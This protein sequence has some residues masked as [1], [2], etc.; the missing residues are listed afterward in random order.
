MN[1]TSDCIMEFKTNS[2]FVIYGRYFYLPLVLSTCLE[3]IYT[4]QYKYWLCFLN[5]GIKSS[6]HD[7]NSQFKYLGQWPNLVTK[8]PSVNAITKLLFNNGSLT[9]GIDE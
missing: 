4:L 5:Q 9:F 7:L 2:T 6:A 3:P 1:I 8:Q